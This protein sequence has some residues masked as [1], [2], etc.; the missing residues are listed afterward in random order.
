VRFDVRS[1]VRFE[2]R[3][4]MRFDERLVEHFGLRLDTQI[5]FPAPG[6]LNLIS[7][8]KEKSR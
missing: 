8:R 4:E 5:Y 2:M 6:L 1:D 7:A 3:F